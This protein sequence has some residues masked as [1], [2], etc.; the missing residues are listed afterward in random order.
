MA[1]VRQRDAQTYEVHQGTGF[2]GNDIAL[3]SDHLGQEPE[4]GAFR[5]NV[6]VK[7]VHPAEQ[8][9]VFHLESVVGG[10]DQGPQVSVHVS[11]LT[12][13]VVGRE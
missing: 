12:K 13:R 6:A 9:R 7:G 3:A 2:A 5:A 11:A 8:E 4:T 10:T 1:V